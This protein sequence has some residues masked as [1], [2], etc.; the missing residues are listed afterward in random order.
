MPAL[1]RLGT[2][3]SCPRKAVGMARMISSSPAADDVPADGVTRRIRASATISA[4][5][6]RTAPSARTWAMPM[7]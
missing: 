4:L 1:R 3:G 7:W 6:E 2:F 5:M